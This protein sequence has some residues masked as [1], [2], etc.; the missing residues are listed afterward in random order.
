MF[1]I[2][3]IEILLFFKQ[4]G[5]AVVGASAFW[6]LILLRGARRAE[7]EEKREV[8]LHLSQKVLTPL[9]ISAII[10]IVAWIAIFFVNPIASVAHEGVVLDQSGYE[11]AQGYGFINILFFLLAVVSAVGFGW[12][13]KNKD[14][15]N[16]RVKK[17]YTTEFVLA[18]ILLSVPVWTGSFGTEQLFF[19]GHS[20]HSIFTIGTVLVLDFIFFSSESS[21]RIKRQLYPL[22][23]TVSKVIWVGLGIEFASVLF[24]LDEALMLT[25]KF[26]FMQTVIAILIINGAFL[27]GPINRKLIESVSGDGVKELSRGWTKAAGVAGVISISSWGTITFL[28]FIKNVTAAYWQLALVYVGAILL[29]YV[30]YQVV[31]R[32]R[33]R[34]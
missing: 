25:P 14:K 27:A 16:A 11:N 21:P 32:S 7:N 4:L 30:A 2:Q 5:L 10:A 12:Y 23:P 33:P 24:V 3:A 6:G 1:N 8:C 26:F 20:L 18:A 29:A 15:F 22:L 19:L 34:L 17:F 9:G 31:E 28:D 13:K